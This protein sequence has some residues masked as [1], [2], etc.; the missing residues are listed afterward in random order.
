M[1]VDDV[2]LLQSAQIAALQ[3]SV[4]R[5]LEEQTL[6]KAEVKALREENGRLWAAI[7][8]DDGK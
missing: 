5:V 6:L 7:I 4:S 8:G 2:E 3:A 1:M